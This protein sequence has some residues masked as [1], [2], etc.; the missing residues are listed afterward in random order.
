MVAM[1]NE[2]Y[3]SEWNALFNCFLPS[4]KLVR[5]E[6]IGAKVIKHY[7]QPRTP[8]ERILASSHIKAKTKRI[9]RQQYQQLNPYLLQRAIRKK[10]TAVLKLATPMQ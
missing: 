7:D 3:T 5:K 8:L 4:M 2:L 1:M 9:L 6:R 10:I